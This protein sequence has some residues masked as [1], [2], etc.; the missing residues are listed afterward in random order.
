[1][2]KRIK[3][4]RNLFVL[5]DNDDFKILSRFN[6]QADPNRNKTKYYARRNNGYNNKGTR[7][8]MPM[9]RQIMKCPSGYEVDH[10]N[11]D[12]LDNRKIN[13]RVCSHLKNIQNQKSRGGK[14]IY[15]G[16][17]K[18]HDGNWR[19]RITVNYKRI[20]LGVFKTQEN[21]YEAVK[22]AQEKYYG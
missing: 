21:A 6:W 5:V 14:S 7:L 13:L 17:T 12:T 10:I 1:L 20:S 3:L 4:T 19:A 15:R 8:K 22:K 9:H 18:H 16:V 2:V 11:G